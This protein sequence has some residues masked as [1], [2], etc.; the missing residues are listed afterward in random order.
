MRDKRYLQSDNIRGMANRALMGGGK[1]ALDIRAHDLDGVL[2]RDP[3]SL[4]RVPSSGR[5]LRN[6][7]SDKEVGMQS[8]QRGYR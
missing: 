7:K 1:S 5:I 6:V 4:S 8:T 3:E 2:V